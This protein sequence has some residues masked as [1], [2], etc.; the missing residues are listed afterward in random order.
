MF[1]NQRKRLILIDKKSNE[2]YVLVSGLPFK[3]KRI[4]MIFVKN[5]KN[6]NDV[7][8]FN[9]ISFKF[10]VLLPTLLACFFIFLLHLQFMFQRLL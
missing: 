8:R 7:K 10:I 6:D 9:F 4:N 3:K 5:K 2:K 1:S